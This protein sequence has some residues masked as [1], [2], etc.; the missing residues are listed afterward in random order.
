[1]NNYKFLIFVLITTI[2]QVL[3]INERFV[4]AQQDTLFA[5]D[6][7][8]I[9]DIPISDRSNWFD[10]DGNNY[11]D[12]LNIFGEG[13]LAININVNDTLS[14]VYNT[15]IYSDFSFFIDYN[16]DKY[17]DIL[18]Y[19]DVILNA[20]GKLVNTNT[21]ILGYPFGVADLNNDGYQDI[22]SRISISN[23]NDILGVLINQL[24]GQFE[25]RQSLNIPNSNPD[26]LKFLDFNGR[27]N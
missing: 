22:L 17:V 9:N 27:T 16:Q 2:I 4:F 15:G 12:I 24:N 21:P 25:L 13:E 23:G 26:Y 1:M 8:F 11:V 14:S 5:G 7:I 10:Y 19:N 20:S 6:V 3:D 18:S